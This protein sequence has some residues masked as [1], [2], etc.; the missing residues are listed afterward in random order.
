MFRR[1]L[2]AYGFVFLASVGT[3]YGWTSAQAWGFYVWGA[4][5][6]FWPDGYTLRVKKEEEK[7]S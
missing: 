7:K 4:F 2:L 5:M 1:I 6:V 3:R